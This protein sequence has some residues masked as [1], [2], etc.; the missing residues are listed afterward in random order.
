MSL[1]KCLLFL[2]GVSVLSM[3]SA[4]G[5]GESSSPSENQELVNGSTASKPWPSLACD[6]PAPNSQRNAYF[7]ELHLHTEYSLD[8][9]ATRLKPEDAYRFALGEAVA[10]PPYDEAGNSL[11]PPHQIDRPL[12][13]AAIT[14]HGEWLGERQLCTDPTIDQVAYYSPECTLFR[15]DKELGF[16][17]FG[18][19]AAAFSPDIFP[20]LE[21]GSLD[22]LTET[23]KQRA[24]FCGAL[25]EKCEAAARGP[26]MDTQLQ[27]E[28]FNQPGC[29]TT[30][31][32]YEY[33]LSPQSDNLHRNVIFRGTEVPTI[34]VS[35]NEAPTPTDLWRELDEAC[36]GDCEYLTI[37]HNSN[38][39]NGRMFASPNDVDASDSYDV[40]ERRK[41]EP[42]IEIFQVK[43]SSE[44]S[45]SEGASED[46]PLCDFEQLA[47]TNFVQFFL[48]VNPL[49]VAPAYTN[50]VRYG[51]K[52]G[53]LLER[54]FGANPFQYGFVA[55]TDSHF[56]LPG[57]VDEQNFPGHRDV[58]P[59]NGV[60][61]DAYNNPGG[62]AVAWAEE[63][64]RD[65]LFDAFKR[66][67][68]YAT[69]GPR[70]QLRVFGGNQSG[71]P[72]NMCQGSGESF[73]RQGDAG[74]VPMGGELHVGQ[75]RPRL[76]IWA[77][78]DA[79]PREN[80]RTKAVP[81]ARMQV[82]K[83]WL[84]L[85][86]SGNPVTKH[87]V[88][89]V[90][91]AEQSDWQVDTADCSVSGSGPAQLCG[92]W[93]D[94]DFEPSQSA[95]YYA[96]VVEQ[97]TCRWLTRQCLAAPENLDCDNPPEEWAGCCAVDTPPT[98]QERAWASP[99]WYKQ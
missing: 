75:G 21:S 47:S 31:N 90:A 7:G 74:G 19:G 9:V 72:E 17:L 10:A 26:W 81:L 2:A 63:N 59:V 22:S 49:P 80:G 99:I 5:G 35:A 39:S 82:I 54:Q 60:K 38:L 48:G 71:L 83:G 33:T 67:E 20:K 29:F 28:R 62:L 64:T 41:A 45:Q 61:D 77:A 18:G 57:S 73:V 15:E 25:G 51:L 1:R 23:G 66:K 86:E 93:D 14:D 70:L 84:E 98:V 27:A 46:D 8:A 52:Q 87:K 11:V 37:P 95:F 85:D 44:C 79:W 56:G 91:G 50:T 4:C 68:T 36:T 13:F 6:P 97:P 16:L 3:L 94:P 78:A 55:S 69:S 24:P 32:A 58:P 43:G 30:F 76:A 12:D 89:D 42:L 34:P 96:R 40:D 92:V 65:A 88:Y 53:L